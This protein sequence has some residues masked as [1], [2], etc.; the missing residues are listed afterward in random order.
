MPLSD[1]KEII[2]QGSGGEDAFWSR[3]KRC[4]SAL[5]SELEA[6][7]SANSTQQRCAWLSSAEFVV[8]V[9]F[10]GRDM[11]YAPRNTEK[12]TN[13]NLSNTV[14]GQCFICESILSFERLVMCCSWQGGFG[15]LPISIVESKPLVIDGIVLG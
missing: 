4:I 7:R 12:Q 2:H 5:A 1:D 3:A 11:E 9:F 8:P 14:H 10:C 6:L 13:K 15:F